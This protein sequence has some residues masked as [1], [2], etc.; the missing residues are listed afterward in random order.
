MLPPWARHRPGPAGSARLV[1]A[2]FERALRELPAGM[3]AIAF[4]AAAMRLRQELSA[5]YDIEVVGPRSRR[6]A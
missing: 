5:R 6:P 1:A 3:A 4:D 2:G